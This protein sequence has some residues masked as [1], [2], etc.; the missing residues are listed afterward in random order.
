MFFFYANQIY[1]FLCPGDE[2]DPVAT[3]IQ[4]PDTSIFTE[5][6][7]Q[8]LL[9]ICTIF[10]TDNH[11]NLHYQRIILLYYNSNKLLLFYLK[12]DK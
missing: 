3:E 4:S 5:R 11:R 10:I 2:N 1:L 7:L 8:E 12:V 9:V 6:R